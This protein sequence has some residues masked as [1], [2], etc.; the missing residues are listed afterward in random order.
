MG[1][2]YCNY[3][4]TDTIIQPYNFYFIRNFFIRTEKARGPP[5][6]FINSF[7]SKT[8][9]QVYF[10]GVINREFKTNKKQLILKI[11]EVTNNFKM[12]DILISTNGD[13]YGL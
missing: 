1:D 13:V 5:E 8:L 11:G 2:E 4:Y 3:L 6:N 9:D 10:I 12:K 7:W